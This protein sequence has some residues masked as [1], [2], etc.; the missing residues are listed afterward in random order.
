MKKEKN[1][2]EKKKE[3]KR[4]EKKKFQ[5]GNRTRDLNLPPSIPPAASGIDCTYPPTYTANLNGHELRVASLAAL[6]P[7]IIR[8][9]NTKLLAIWVPT[10]EI[11]YTCTHLKVSY[12]Y[13]NFGG[14]MTQN[15]RLKWLNTSIENPE[16]LP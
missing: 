16:L 9:L 1:G 6:T 7:P 14:H 4:S 8:T 2:R 11:R 5:W 13:R 15:G 10:Y 12:C 3:K